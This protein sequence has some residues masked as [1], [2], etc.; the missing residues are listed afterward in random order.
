M[1]DAV[2]TEPRFTICGLEEI[3]GIGQYGVTH[4]LSILD[5]DREEPKEFEKYVRHVRTTL[6]FH[7]ELEDRPG[8]ELPQPWHVATI[9]AFGRDHVDD[10]GHLLVHCHAGMSRSTA[11][12]A[13][14]MAQAEPETDED[15]IFTRLSAIR[16][17]AWPNLRMI[18]FA[19]EALGR[20]GRMV[21]AV[22]RLY[23]RRIKEDPKL[24]ALI[25]RLH[26]GREIDL[27]ERSA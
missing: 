23:A 26:R 14:I 19:D 10:L 1:T 16:S 2:Q 22:G 5:P 18:E 15:A 6:R 7:D 12:M 27:A 25:R 9:L 3:E 11:A 13:M 24:P 17:I 21:A 8:V 4:V 20:N